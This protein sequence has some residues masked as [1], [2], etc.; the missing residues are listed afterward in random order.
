MPEREPKT[1]QSMDTSKIQF[2]KPVGFIAARNDSD[3]YITQAYSNMGD[4]S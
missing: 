4:S 3:S 1:D 2:G